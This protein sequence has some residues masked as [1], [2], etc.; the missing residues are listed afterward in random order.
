[1]LSLSRIYQKSLLK[2][3]KKLKIKGCGKIA[4]TKRAQVEV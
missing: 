4:Q 3:S 2:R 1:V